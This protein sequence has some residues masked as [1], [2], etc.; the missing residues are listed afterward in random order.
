MAQRSI[1]VVVPLRENR[2][3][4]AFIGFSS[5]YLS[6]QNLVLLH[7][8]DR[9]IQVLDL[10]VHGCVL[11]LKVF[12]DEAVSDHIFEVINTRDHHHVI[13]SRGDVT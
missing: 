2:L 3:M 4:W 9:Q 7:W 13:I 10:T 6:H 1:L 11:V 5:S 12:K 8:P